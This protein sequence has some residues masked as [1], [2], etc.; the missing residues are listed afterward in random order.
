MSV[1]SPKT[2]ATLLHADALNVSRDPMLMLG[3]FMSLLPVPLLIAFGPLAEAAAL[4]AFGFSGM[5]RMLGA[6]AVLMAGSMLGWV[7]GFL[8][9]EDRDDAVLMALETTP[10]GRTGFLSYRL[11]L[12]A[13]LTFIISTGIGLVVLPTIPVTTALLAAIAAGHAVLTAL[14]LLAFAGNKVEGLALTKLINIALLAPLAV[15]IAPPWRYLAGMVP[16]FWIGEMTQVA[17]APLSPLLA[18]AIALATT[19]LF[20]ILL[21]QRLHLRSD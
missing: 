5:A 12:T 19:A 21:V 6:I 10:I 17:P 18:A 13:L 11:T 3:V 16:A 2:M 4:D 9:L 20:V 8:L 15:L 14:F 7:T 1:L